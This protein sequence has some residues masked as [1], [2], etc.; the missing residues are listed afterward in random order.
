MSEFGARRLGSSQA[1]LCPKLAI[2]G[3]FQKA[4]TRSFGALAQL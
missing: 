2:R 4:L 1:A 3:E